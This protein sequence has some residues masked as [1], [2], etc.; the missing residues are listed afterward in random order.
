MVFMAIATTVFAQSKINFESGNLD[1]L[2]GQSEVNVQFLFENAKFQTDNYT[3][4]QYLERRKKESLEKK[5]EKFWESWI[6]EW[7]NHR[8]VV[9]FN[10]FIDGLNEKAKKIKFGKDL[11]TKYTLIIDSKWIY[12]GWSGFVMQPG[13]LSTEIRIVET[14]N[15]SKV[16]TKIQTDKIEG[17]GSKVNY[18]MEYGRISAAYEKTGKELGKEIKNALK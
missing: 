14:D 4:E 9:F 17:T 1:I 15:P 6:G 16:L 18:G 7:N 10:K 12:A 13:K 3:E 2:K 5:T 8:N 11:K